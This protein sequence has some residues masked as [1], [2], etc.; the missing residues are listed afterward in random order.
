MHVVQALIG[1]W[2]QINR[3]ALRMVPQ[4]KIERWLEQIRMPAVAALFAIAGMRQFH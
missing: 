2:C 4:K 3:H 1:L